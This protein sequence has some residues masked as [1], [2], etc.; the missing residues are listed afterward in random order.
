MP[1]R[2]LFLRTRSSHTPTTLLRYACFLLALTYCSLA[3]EPGIRLVHASSFRMM[4]S[5]TLLLTLYSHPPPFI[6]VA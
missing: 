6:K 5:L 1:F 3:A 2:G 4:H